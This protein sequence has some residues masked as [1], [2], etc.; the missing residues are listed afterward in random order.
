M[1]GIFLVNKKAGLT[2]HD[3]VY[4]IRKKFNIKKVGHTGTLDPFATGLLIILVGKATKLAFLFDELDKQ[5]DGTI[6][7]GK[8]YDTDDTTGEVINEAPVSFTEDDL[9]A[10]LNRIV[11]TYKQIPP[12]YSAI[13]K[14]GVKAYE[15]ARSGKPLD[16]PA[17]EVSIYNFT[18]QINKQTIDFSTHVSKGTYIRSIAR[19]IGLGLNTFG[20]L[21][22]LNRTNIDSYSQNMSKTVEDTELPDLIDHALLFEGVKKIVLNDY[23]IK[24]VKNGV[25]LDERQTTLNE[26]FI[27][28][29][30]MGNYIAYYVPDNQQY[31]LKYL[32]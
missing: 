30:E 5:Y 27:V 6:V 1:N 15:A 10:I 24:L 25:V 26:P 16:L 11:P 4:Q 19:D 17:R 28:Q 8:S 9:K 31:K 14:A 23:L 12:S 2:S 20:E 13:K 18:Y 29:D 32:F 7:L 22:V 3:I 21:S